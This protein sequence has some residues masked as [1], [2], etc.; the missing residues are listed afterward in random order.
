MRHVLL[1]LALALV[2]CAPQVQTPPAPTPPPVVVTP[3]PAPLPACQ[4]VRLQHFPTS[5][6]ITPVVEGTRPVVRASVGG[7]YV[8]ALRGEQ[9][10]EI[11]FQGLN[12]AA[13]GAVVEEERVQIDLLGHVTRTFVACL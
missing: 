6:L 13:P 3:A 8:G 1:L 4:L 5:V 2:A 10:L 12:L 9:G 7:A 11:P